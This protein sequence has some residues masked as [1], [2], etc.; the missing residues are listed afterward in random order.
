MY[1][2][3]DEQ[4]WFTATVPSDSYFAI[5]FGTSM[6]DTGIIFLSGQRGSPYSSGYYG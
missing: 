1:N 2:T 4:L 6:Y 5:G 3:T